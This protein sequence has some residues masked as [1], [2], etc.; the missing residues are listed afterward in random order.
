MDNKGLVVLTIIGTI[1]L[2]VGVSFLLTSALVYAITWA[3]GYVF[4]WRLAFGVWCVLF[5]IKSV[6]SGSRKGE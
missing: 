5:L 4:T 6:F 1:A 2:V 3:F